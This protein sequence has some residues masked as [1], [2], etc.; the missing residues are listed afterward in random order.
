[1][2]E[3]LYLVVAAAS[4]NISLHSPSPLYKLPTLETCCAIVSLEHNGIVNLI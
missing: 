2:K 3:A 1:M 4:L